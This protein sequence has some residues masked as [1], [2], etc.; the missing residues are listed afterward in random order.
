M[1]Y[2]FNGKYYD[3]PNNI[4][5]DQL[6]DFFN[7]KNNLSNSKQQFQQPT[8]QPSNSMNSIWQRKKAIEQLT[9]GNRTGFDTLRDASYG[10][11]TGILNLGNLINQ[12]ETGL[13]NLFR[14]DKLTPVKNNI[15]WEKELSGLA[16]PNQSIGGEIIKGIGQYAPVGAA[17]ALSGGAAIPL[18]LGGAVSGAANAKP[19]Q[20]NLDLFG[21]IP[22]GLLPEGQTG[23][24]IEGAG[25]NVIPFGLGKALEK[26]RPSKMFRGQLSP[27][28]LQAN[29]EATKG[30]E[31][32]LSDVIR[33][34]KL[35]K[36]YENKIASIPLSGADESFLRTGK[37][38]ETKG[39]DILSDLLGDNKPTNV[40]QD[41]A[42]ELN[43]QYYLRRIEKNS[44]YDDFNQAADQ[45]GI[46]LALP[47]FANKAK[48][49]ADAIE[50]TNLLK[51]EPEANA[52]FK[53]LQNYKNPVKES[54]DTLYVDA[55]GNADNKLFPSYKEANLLKGHL[56]EMAK[57]AL[58]STDIGQRNLSGVFSNLAKSIK[59]D[60]KDSLKDRP[61][62]L[63][64]YN[65]AEEN[66]AKNFSPFLD[67]QIYKFIGGDANPEKIVTE[68]IKTS[69]NEDLADN[70]TKLSSKMPEE[71][72][73]LLGYAY[74]SR[75]LDN[76]SK[77]N[78]AALATAIEKLGP[79]QLEA[80]FSND[81]TRKNILNYKKL[82]K[83]NPEALSVMYNPKTGNRLKGLV[84]LLAA[85]NLGGLVNGPLT[86]A[87]IGGGTMGASRLATKYL[88]NENVRNK[89]VAEMIKNQNKFDKPQINQSLA[90]ALQSLA[91][92]Q[93]GNQ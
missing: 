17:V 81:E 76:E 74:L 70:L 20:S 34:P 63:K 75:A 9:G 54:D 10:A 40:P 72:K 57:K 26:L 87:A 52:L 43:R 11:A 16:S 84:S 14:K 44:Y 86:A 5:N 42:D 61:N 8:T 4:T 48:E 55:A 46:N 51:T 58:Q 21:F 65:N 13:V 7:E 39:Y 79:R 66:Y 28:E 36:L 71:Q 93:Q 91:L 29:V 59:T 15:D 53:K 60:I 22:D 85:T 1:I 35:K 56:N 19:N 88:T 47:T 80:L 64:K 62:I 67:K 18:L 82:V 12:G 2:Q 27:E 49:Y 23:A 6:N 37:Q 33:S 90:A 83:L 3:L 89:L 73:N 32:P 68:F 24:A 45:S 69:K 31:T 78:P 25:L 41:L 92:R 50:S 38:I 77:L 30:T